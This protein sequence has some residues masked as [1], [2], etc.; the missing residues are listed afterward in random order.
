MYYIRLYVIFWKIFH[1]NSF[2]L[3]NVQSILIVIDY[4][5][6]NSKSLL[7]FAD[8]Y[9]GTYTKAQTVNHIA[10]HEVPL[11]VSCISLVNNIS[12]N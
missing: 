8:Q 12:S 10:D 9:N 5:T 4:D 6:K 7:L 3:E 2:Q 11:H 1:K